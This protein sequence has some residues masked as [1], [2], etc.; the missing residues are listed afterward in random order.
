[1]G[2]V[3]FVCMRHVVRMS[4]LLAL[5]VVLLSVVP[6]VLCVYNT[7][8]TI[9]SITYTIASDDSSSTTRGN[10]TDSGGL[11]YQYGAGQATV[12][13]GSF[14]TVSL[15]SELGTGFCQYSNTSWTYSS[16][17]DVS[18]RYT[19]WSSDEY[20]DYSCWIPLSDVLNGYGTCSHT[21][22]VNAITVQGVDACTGGTACGSGC[23][24]PSTYCNLSTGACCQQ[25]VPCGTMSLQ[26]H[27]FLQP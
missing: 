9:I 7:N 10:C 21:T 14:V 13:S 3:V 15:Y 5:M 24:S 4:T 1:M 8:N 6:C 25:V 2:L 27:R 19:L 23:C 17:G 20:I 12:D 26:Q 16:N 11:G 22:L 18:F